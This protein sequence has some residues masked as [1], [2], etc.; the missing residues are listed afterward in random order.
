MSNHVFIAASIDGYIARADGSID[1]LT[2]LDNPDDSDYGY[3]GF[4]AMIDAIVMGRNTFEFARSIEPWPYDR[5][6]FVLSSTLDPHRDKSGTFE[7]VRLQPADL[8]AELKSRGFNNLYIDGG[9]T[10]QGFLAEDL[11]DEM[12]ITRVPIVLGSGIPLFDA[13]CGELKFRHIG[14]TAYPNGLVTSTYRRSR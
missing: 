7:V 11:I 9:K 2:G 5:P 1:W 6:V 12:T 4:I 8:V 14:T 10:I 13:S 3:G